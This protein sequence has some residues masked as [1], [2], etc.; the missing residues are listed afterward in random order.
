MTRSE[1][2]Y[3]SN[4]NFRQLWSVLKKMIFLPRK[5]HHTFFN[6]F[7]TNSR[8]TQWLM[9]CTVWLTQHSTAD[10]MDVET[11]IMCDEANKMHNVAY[12]VTERA[13][14]GRQGSVLYPLLLEKNKLLWMNTYSRHQIKG[15]NTLHSGGAGLVTLNFFATSNTKMGLE[16]LL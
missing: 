13:V 11:E 14:M 15:N 16:R 12:I 2:M 4:M 9:S 7:K 5:C 8:L 3:C 10:T 1:K 6:F